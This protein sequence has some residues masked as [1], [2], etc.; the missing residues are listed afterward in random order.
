MSVRNE[1]AGQ[2]TTFSVR[3]YPDFPGSTEMKLAVPARDTDGGYWPVGTVFQPQS[4]GFSSGDHGD[5]QDVRIE[6]KSVRFVK[7]SSKQEKEYRV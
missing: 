7:R 4:A 2:S 5:Y 6:G 1:F 3:A